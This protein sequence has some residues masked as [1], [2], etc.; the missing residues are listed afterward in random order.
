MLTCSHFLS[1]GGTYNI[2]IGRDN[3]SG[4]DTK[5]TIYDAAGNMLA[6]DDG[7]PNKGPASDGLR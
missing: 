1:T 6:Y 5:V 2:S 3:P 4:V 7:D